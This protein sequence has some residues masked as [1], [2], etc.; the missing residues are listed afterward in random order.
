MAMPRAERP[1]LL[2]H[3]THATLVVETQ[4]ARTTQAAEELL[5]PLVPSA[6]AN[7]ELEADALRSQITDGSTLEAWD[8]QY[9][10][11]RVR[12]ARYDV[13]TEALKPYFELEHVLHD[14]VFFAAEK[15]YGL[16]V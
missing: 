15:V 6:V 8:W 3:A 1:A 11:E 7:T 14:G 4:P 2:G 10:S 5:H 9:Y 12:K 16:T 13:D